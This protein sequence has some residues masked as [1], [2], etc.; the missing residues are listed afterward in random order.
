MAQ[1]YQS[2]GELQWRSGCDLARVDPV[3]AA[4][5]QLHISQAESNFTKRMALNY[6]VELAISTYC[7]PIF[8]DG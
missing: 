4:I 7:R 5:E 1:K 2:C 8:T 6:L 3:L